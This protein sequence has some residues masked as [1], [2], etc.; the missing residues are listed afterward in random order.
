MRV[1]LADAL[2]MQF[3]AKKGTKMLSDLNMDQAC[4]IAILAGSARRQRDLLL[5]NVAEKDLGGSEPWPWRAQS[6]RSVGIRTAHSERVSND[7]F[8]R[9]NCRVVGKSA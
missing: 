6:N 3:S 7:S 5:G 9:G 2:N 4:F 8:A 1:M